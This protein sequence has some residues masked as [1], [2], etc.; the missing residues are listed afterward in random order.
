MCSGPWAEGLAKTA[1]GPSNPANFQCDGTSAFCSCPSATNT[2]PS[3]T[4]TEGAPSGDGAPWAWP[5]T[6]MPATGWGR[7]MASVEGVSARA[8]YQLVEPSGAMSPIWVPAA[9]SCLASESGTSTLVT[10]S[11]VPR[12]QVARCSADRLR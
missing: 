8:R 5:S 2:L 9:A 4:T 12:Y 7:V 10:S 3:A 6:A 1:N 11:G